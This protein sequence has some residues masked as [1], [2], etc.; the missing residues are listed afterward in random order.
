MPDPEQET[1]MADPA[2]Q[3]EIP[4]AWKLTACIVLLFLV[5]LVA[6]LLTIPFSCLLNNWPQ[7]VCWLLSSM[8]S[9][10]KIAE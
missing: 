4:M 8:I 10:A 5:S 9:Q 2:R 6:L 7:P 1:R 3:D